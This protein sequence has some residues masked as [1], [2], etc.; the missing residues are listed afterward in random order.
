MGTGCRLMMKLDF[1]VD[2]LLLVQKTWKEHE[3]GSIQ[4]FAKDLL[5]GKLKYTAAKPAEVRKVGV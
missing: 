3:Y 5:M 1:T 2:E 4:E